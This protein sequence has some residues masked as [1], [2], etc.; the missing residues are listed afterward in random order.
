MVPS[1][2][3]WFN[4]NFSEEKY[5][6][7]LDELCSKHPGAIEFRVA[8]TPVFIDKAF[9]NKILDCCESIVDVI[10]Q[11]N[12]NALVKM[13]YRKMWLFRM[14]HHTPILLLLI[15]VSVKMK[16]VNWNHS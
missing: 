3:K 1:M 7:Y 8:E 13:Q 15:L 10:T 9:T 16:T 5:K 4:E 14:K 12:F 11:P 6:A 2:R